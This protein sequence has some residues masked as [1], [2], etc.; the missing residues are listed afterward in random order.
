[1]KKFLVFTAL[2]V[3]SLGAFAQNQYYVAATGGSDSNSG[4]S[5][6]SPWATCTHALP[7]AV[8]NGTTGAIINF[9]ASSTTF[10]A[11]PAINRSGA[12]TT[13]RLVLKCTA[14]YT[15]ATHCKIAS[16]F[17]IT[18]ANNVDIGGLPQMGFEYTNPSDD[19][20]VDV[21]WQCGTA[22]TCSS[23]NS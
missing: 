4:T 3:S 15:A 17:L 20:G 2:L 11:C 12:S 6:G 22:Q 8:I 1:M 23:G 18:S 16:H 5:L 10:A 7:T 21:S 14:P 19:V 13:A 9:I